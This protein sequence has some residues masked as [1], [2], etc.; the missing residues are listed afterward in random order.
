MTAR[1][2]F[3]VWIAG[4]AGDGIASAGESFAKACSRLGLHVFAYNSYQSVIRG[5]HVCMHIR[6]G[7]RVVETQ[8]DNAC[9]F[10]IALN[11]DSVLRYGKMVH[12]RGSII[13]NADKLKVTPEL[14]GKDAQS[15][16]LP[17]MELTKNNP[18]M[19]NIVALG[20]LMYLLGLSTTGLEE[21]VRER[22]QKKGEQ[23]IVANL[24]AMQAGFEHAKAHN[25]PSD[26]TVTGDGKR[27][28]LMAGNPAIG[29][30]ALA[31]G[32]R[33]YSAYPMTPASS[34][35][36]WLVKYAARTGVLVKQ[37]EDE[38]A[39]LNMAIGAGH[40]GVRA[41]TGTSGGGFA[42][43][44]EAVGEAGMT[45]TPVVIVMA[46][47][48]GPSTGLPTKTE[49]GDLFQALGA[50]Q[51]DFPKIILAPRT[52]EECYTTAIEA[53]NLADKFQCP[54]ILL[55][56]LYLAES[57]Q[58]V[59]GVDI[60]HIPIDRGPLLERV[61]NGG[62]RRFA[63]T[64]TG[65]SPRALPG[66]P[67][68]CYVSATDEHD[69]DG[70]VISDVF[71]NPPTRV[72]MMDKRMR[73]I[74]FILQD[75]PKPAIEGPADADLTLVGWGSTCSV[76]KETVHVLTREGFKVNMLVLRNLWPFQD[77]EV[78]QLLR[79]CKVTMSVEGNFSGQLVQLIRMRTGIAIQH[80]LRKYDGEPFNPSH[81]IEQARTIL[82]EKPKQSIIAT[83]ITDEGLPKDFS[84]VAA[85][86]V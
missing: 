81:V 6:V 67:G 34:L 16:G 21:L 14:L 79:R 70:I 66:T 72:K 36:H 40:V 83:V 28:L 57:L 78:A 71:T 4:A 33:F 25:K 7:S 65:V 43:M 10:L 26:I 41:M 42:L 19:Q 15:C 69:E 56:D 61:E 85:A 11:M 59:D 64:E 30:G 20:T 46:M 48:G 77:E 63:D 75:L 52:V 18:L 9:D 51:G 49:Q 44:T 23:V 24:S 37:C 35:L 53:F 8:G 3:T 29:L 74:K 76:L 47:R 1:D 32:C 17:I 12:P 13:F 82:I 68:I 31:A 22:F 84:P 5:G 45:E 55:T 60:K 73:K 62:Y 39:A 58:T 54:V 86:H 80:H 50:S 27:R 2:E 38:I